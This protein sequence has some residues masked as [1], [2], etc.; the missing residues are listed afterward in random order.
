[1]EHLPGLACL[2]PYCCFP[3]HV[4]DFFLPARTASSFPQPAFIY[5]VIMASLTLAAGQKL[6]VVSDA[7]HAA[8]VEAVAQAQ[9]AGASATVWEPSTIEDVAAEFSAGAGANFNAALLVNL[10]ASDDAFAAVLDCLAE[11]ADV[12]VVQ[13]VGAAAGGQQA[14]ADEAKAVVNALLLG[15]FALDESV[16]AAA[17]L[18][19]ASGLVVLRVKVPAW[20]GAVVELRKP[21]AAG[22]AGDAAAAAAGARALFNALA[23]DFDNGAHDVVDEDAL[24]GEA[25]AAPKSAGCAPPAAGT[26]KRACKNCTCGACGAVIRCLVLYCDVLCC[27]RWPAGWDFL[28]QVFRRALLMCIRRLA[29]HRSCRWCTRAG[30]KDLEGNP[31]VSE[32]DLDELVSKSSSG[33]CGN[34]SKGDAFRCSGCVRWTSRY[35][36][37]RQVMGVVVVGAMMMIVTT[38]TTNPASRCTDVAGWLDRWWVVV[39]APACRARCAHAGR[40]T[41]CGVCRRVIVALVRASH[42]G[43]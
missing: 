9:A 43:D 22:A 38:M 37:W 27:A 14:A 20:S 35:R 39:N 28:Q 23:S 24:L 40:L 3:H 21:A 2:L 33:G 1:M 12:R 16:A 34:C 25:P 31:A 7:A 29:V 41:S 32:A 8:C 17:A 6:L 13:Q 10:G 36:R 30:L 19:D 18:P 42:V 15:G 5:L 11:G 26:R 4:E